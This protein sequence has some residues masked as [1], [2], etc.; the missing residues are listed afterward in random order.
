[1]HELNLCRHVSHARIYDVTENLSLLK[2]WT[3]NVVNSLRVKSINCKCDYF[4]SACSTRNRRI[5][6][7]PI[8]IPCV[9]CLCL[10]DRVSCQ[11]NRATCHRMY[12]PRFVCL[13]LT[14][15]SGIRS[16]VQL[17]TF[18]FQRFWTTVNKFSYRLSRLMFCT[19]TD[20]SSDDV[21]NLS[22][23]Q[24]SFWRDLNCTVKSWTVF[25]QEREVEH[26]WHHD[27]SV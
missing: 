8:D 17:V 25:M 23:E 10:L 16:F 15:G 22:H 26:L 6:S 13:T 14:H 21:C 5:K 19:L 20:A 27:I 18:Y 9:K 4:R 11:L 12:V 2:S 24:C 7:L 3:W 1:M